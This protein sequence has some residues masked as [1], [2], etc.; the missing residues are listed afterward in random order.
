MEVIQ[1]SLLIKFPKF[2]H[3]RSNI[4]DFIGACIYFWLLKTY[5]KNNFNKI[6]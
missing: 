5:L 6:M 2:V 3:R 4:T 1:I